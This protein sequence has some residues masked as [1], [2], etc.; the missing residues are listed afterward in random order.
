MSAYDVA[1]IIVTYN[2]EDEIAACLDAVYSE[3]RDVSM[4][5][6]VVD[7]ASSDATVEIVSERYPGVKLLLPGGNLGFSKGVNYGARHSDAD[8][9]LLLNPDTVVRRHAI[10]VIVGFARANPR[11]GLYGGRTLKTD[12]SLEPLS[13]LGLPTLCS[14]LMF[15][16]GLSSLAPGSPLLNP[17]SLGGWK[18]D[19][20]REVGVITGCFLLVRTA[21]WQKL[22][23][24]DESYFMYGEDVDFA[25]RARALG[26]RPVICPDAELVHKLGTSS[27]SPAHKMLLLYRGKAS[28]MRKHWRGWRLKAGLFLLAAGTGL[29]ALPSILSRPLHPDGNRWRTVWRHRRE[30]LCG[31]GRTIVDQTPAN[32]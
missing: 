23:G 28:L 2:S 12:G 5:V 6:I 11:Y 31:Y 10:D 17:E 20:V 21:I 3:R 13:C 26:Y 9:V 19:T 24:L 7:N 29:R 32:S 27:E 30:W 18:R 8:F 14:M 15:A 25:I 4:Q 1:V 16:T 22:G